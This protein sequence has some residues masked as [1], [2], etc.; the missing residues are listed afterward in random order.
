VRASGLGLVNR[1]HAEL[2][3]L[4]PGYQQQIRTLAYRERVR[5]ALPL[6]QDNEDI[7]A[8]LCRRRLQRVLDIDS[9]AAA[10]KRH[11]DGLVAESTR[12]ISG[13]WTRPRVH[14]DTFRAQGSD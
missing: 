2:T 11:I 14:E 8:D 4:H 13:G 10:L 1:V 12:R 5:A 9:E 3:G 7:R 6:L